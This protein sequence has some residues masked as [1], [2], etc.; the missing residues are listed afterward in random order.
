MWRALMR[1]S[2]STQPALSGF[3]PISSGACLRCLESR[4]DKRIR[5][6]SCMGTAQHVRLVSASGF[7]CSSASGAA[8]GGGFELGGAWA[9]RCLGVVEV[10]QEAAAQGEAA[11]ADARGEAV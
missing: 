3:R 5:F 1:S 2:T 9:V 4:L 11:A 6:F 7:A 8:F 10:V